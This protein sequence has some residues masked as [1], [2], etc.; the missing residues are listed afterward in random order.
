MSA[1]IEAYSRMP[2]LYSKNEMEKK[3]FPKV[4]IL[5]KLQFEKKS[6]YKTPFVVSCSNVY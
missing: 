3:T 5:E 6:C 4:V 2:Q 1:A